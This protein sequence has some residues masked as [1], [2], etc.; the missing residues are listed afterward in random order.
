MCLDGPAFS[1]YE[2][3]SARERDSFYVLKERLRS[4]FGMTAYDAFAAFGSRILQAGEVPDTFAVEISRLGQRCGITDDTAFAC[5]FISGLPSAVRT[6]IM[7]QMGLQPKLNS[8]VEAARIL[9]AEPSNRCIAD[10]F[11]SQSLAQLTLLS[12]Q[13]I[14]GRWCAIGAG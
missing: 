2:R 14:A 7:L 10:G 13:H 12:L 1:V 11:V 5:K 9:L 4:A 8:A 6:P 3:M